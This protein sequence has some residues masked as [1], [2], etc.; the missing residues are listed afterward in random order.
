MLCGATFFRSVQGN[1]GLL[2][3]EDNSAEL[4]GA[5]LHSACKRRTSMIQG[6]HKR[7]MISKVGKVTAEMEGTRSCP[8]MLP[9][10]SVRFHTRMEIDGGCQR[11]RTAAIWMS[12]CIT[13]TRRLDQQE[14]A[15]AGERELDLL[16]GRLLRHN[17]L[18]CHDCR[19][20]HSLAVNA[21]FDKLCESFSREG[22]CRARYWNG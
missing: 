14:K 15:I 17:V 8:P 7:L 12:A 16:Q 10:A 2:L 6:R 21:V 18:H 22:R 4:Q 3:E 1:S 9:K 11:V 19:E 20:R 13:Y 5:T